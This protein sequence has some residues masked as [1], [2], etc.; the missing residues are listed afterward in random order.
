MSMD[1]YLK[2]AHNN[3]WGELWPEILLCLGAL[4]VLGLDLFSKSPNNK[5]RISI[6]AIVFQFSILVFIC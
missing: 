6:F 1:I 5:K 4:T 3:L 2:F